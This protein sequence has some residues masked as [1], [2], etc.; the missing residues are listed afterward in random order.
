VLTASWG[1]T[2]QVLAGVPA[3]ELV[4]SIDTA[5]NTRR[6]EHSRRWRVAKISPQ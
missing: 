3:K 2:P 5:K 4:A 1:T 6:M